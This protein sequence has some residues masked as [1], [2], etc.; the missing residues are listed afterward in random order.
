MSLAWFRFKS[1][2][3]WQ[4]I[5]CTASRQELIFFSQ[6]RHPAFKEITVHVLFLLYHSF[7]S[8][9]NTHSRL[10]SSVCI[11]MFLTAYKQVGGCYCFTL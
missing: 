5:V 9:L 7:L 10:H 11:L 3:T 2:V 1:S 6:P 4:I 8:L